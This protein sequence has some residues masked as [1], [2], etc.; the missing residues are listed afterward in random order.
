MNL[1]TDLPDPTLDIELKALITVKGGAL[2][3]LHLREPTSAE[4]HA[5]EVH[6]KLANGPEG[7]TLYTRAL[8]AAVA[9]CQPDDLDGIRVSDL[10]AALT[11]L[12]KFVAAGAPTVDEGFVLPDEETWELALPEPIAF[13]GRDYVTLSLSEPTQVAMRKAQTHLRRG[14][15]AQDIRAYQMHLVTN[16]AAVPYGVVAKLPISVLNT[17]ATYCQGFISGGLATG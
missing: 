12:N 8:V 17:A 4:V 6:L 1:P 9:G 5:A 2:S 15:A 10:K 7:Q 13:Q 3:I 16:V 14:Q 11:Y